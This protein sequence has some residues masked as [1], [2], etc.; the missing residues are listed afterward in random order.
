LARR[1]AAGRSWRGRYLRWRASGGRWP[2]AGAAGGQLLFAAVF[3][4]AGLAAFLAGRGG[5]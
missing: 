2:L 4:G 1:R 5:I 3:V